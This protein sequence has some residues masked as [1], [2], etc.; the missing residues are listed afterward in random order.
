[1]YRLCSS[2]K[3]VNQQRTFCN[4]F[5]ELLQEHTYDDITISQLCKRAG[6][7]RNAFYRLFEKK[8][9]VQYALLDLT[10]LD[11]VEY[12][13][14]ETVGPGGLHSFL[15]FWREQKPLLDALAKH[16]NCS[17][18]TDRVITHILKE[19][20]DVRLCL[21]GGIGNCSEEMIVFYISGLFGLVYCWHKKG[22]DKSIDEMAALLMQIMTTPPAKGPLLRDPWRKM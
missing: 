1:M 2:E 10:I 16:D 19:D 22:F 21:L 12:I 8:A 15:G 4:S 3:S 7:S 9:D 18:L 14:D 17:M 20:E 6:L 5:L 11:S 13:P